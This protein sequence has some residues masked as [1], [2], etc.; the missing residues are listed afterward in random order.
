MHPVQAVPAQQVEVVRRGRRHRDGHRALRPQLQEPLDAARR[1]VGPLALVAVW[2][3]QH[4]IRE[5]TPLG[6]AG[7]DEFVDDRLC[8]VDEVAE[9][10]LPHHDRP[11]VAHRV[12]V[13]EA[14][15]RVLRQRRVVHQEPPAGGCAVRVDGEQVQRGELGGGIR[16]DD[17]RVALRE[18][19][20]TGVLPGEPDQLALGQECAQRQQ[21]T[22]GP[23]HFALVG[24]LPA[25]L[26]HRLDPRVRCELRR[27]GQ[28]RITDA[29]QQC[30]VHRGVHPARDHLRRLD[31]LTRLDSVFLEFPDLVEHLLEL[32][33][34]VA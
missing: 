29:G 24:H 3:Q 7:T 21:F 10:G 33:L 26:Q 20:P 6:L 1:V 25:L 30:L 12:A 34:V 23:V 14:H 17:H 13:L 31:R 28:V 9:L 27:E 32:A 11:G 4:H 8:A 22:E 15:R 18:G 16:V 19:A 5:L 2:Q